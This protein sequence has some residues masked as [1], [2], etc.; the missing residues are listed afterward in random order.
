MSARDPSLPA[1]VL[2]EHQDF[3]RALARGLLGDP[4]RADDAV[5]EAYAAALE[6]PPRLADGGERAL[7]SRSS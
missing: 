3:L 1:D 7:G 2:L 4:A 6:S 5:Q